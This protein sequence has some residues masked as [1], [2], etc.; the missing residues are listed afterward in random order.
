MI[1]PRKSPMLSK[2]K[3]DELIKL[4][5]SEDGEL[6]K[7]KEKPSAPTADDRLTE[8]FKKI[9]EFVET[10]DCM[11]EI[12]SKEINEALLAKRLE[13]IRSNPEKVEALESVDS[14]GLLEMPEAPK[15]ID[16]LFDKDVLGLFTNSE[17]DILNIKNVPTQLRE[18]AKG[19]SIRKKA[20]DFQQH[21]TG[22][23]EQQEGLKNGD[24]KLVR[25]YTVD[26]LHI[27]NYY[28]HDGQMLRIVDV[29]EKK[30]VYDRNK[31]RFRIIFE[32]GT[33][34]N[35]YRRSM[36]QR[37]Y[38]NGHCVVDKDHADP[39]QT[40]LNDDDVKGYVYILSSLSEDPKISTIKDLHKIGFSTTPVADRVKSA[41]KDPTYLMSA[42]EIVD[43]YTLTG[44]YNPQKVEHFLHRIFADA[45]LDLTM[46]D[47]SGEE[48]V[49]R[50]W[51][52]VP[53]PVI[54]Q[55]INLLQSGDIVDY[56]FDSESQT[57]VV[58]DS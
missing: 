23:E 31:E 21:K 48:Y 35:M 22:F 5:E 27:G 9:T 2:D 32:N 39:N 18:P 24:L 8:S 43:T 1:E 41:E 30:R 3:K 13:A 7:P 47:G 50:E 34:S 54:Q 11:P 29:G 28:V 37:L 40:L 44:N 42:V 33:E 14:L 53:L 17:S 52:S 56:I 10:N 38:E 51:Y 55:A 57:L 15:S 12:D 6:F 58:A 46:I 16:E 20:K 19:K 49:P 26:Q 45:A 4:F 36:S 25:Y